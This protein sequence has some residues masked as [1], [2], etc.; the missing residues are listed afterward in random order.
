[1]LVR[2]ASELME[3]LDA[4]LEEEADEVPQVTEVHREI[5]ATHLEKNLQP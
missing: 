1:M 2:R 4:P 5:L 3:I